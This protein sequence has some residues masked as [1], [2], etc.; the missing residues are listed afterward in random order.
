MRVTASRCRRRR[1]RDDPRGRSRLRG[2][3]VHGLARRLGD[4]RRRTPVRPLGSGAS[5][6]KGAGRRASRALTSL[7]RRAAADPETLSQQVWSV[8]IC[9]GADRGIGAND[10]VS[11]YNTRAQQRDERLEVLAA[12][13]HKIAR[14]HI[15]LETLPRPLRLEPPTAASPCTR[16]GRSAQPWWRNDPCPSWPCRGAWLQPRT[17]LPEVWERP[18]VPRTAYGDSMARRI[19]RR[20]LV[21][22]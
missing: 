4:G 21:A 12:N 16:H 14:R 17:R 5:Q 8:L 18:R 19:V 15:E 22:S 13:G 6:A 2:A 9:D 3:G 11:I 20:R 7:Q 10:S 1:G